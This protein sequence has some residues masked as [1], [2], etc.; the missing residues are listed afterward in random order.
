MTDCNCYRCTGAVYEY[1]DDGHRYVV[2]NLHGELQPCEDCGRPKS[3]YR[4]YGRWGE[5]VCWWCK[6]RK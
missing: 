6:E 4:D 2:N 5:Y 3:E 1:D